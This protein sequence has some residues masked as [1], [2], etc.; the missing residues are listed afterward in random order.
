MSRIFLIALIFAA[1]I[2]RALLAFIPPTPDQQAAALG[3][4]DKLPPALRILLTPDATFP[5]IPVP[6]EN[7]W[8]A[9]HQ[10]PGQTFAKY[11]DT[12]PNRPDQYR[13][14]IYL[15]PLGEFPEN[16]SP[17]LETLRSYAA[18]YFQLEVQLLPAQLVDSNIFA[19]RANRYTG[20][21]QLLTA[22][23]F[24]Y[25]RDQLPSDAYCLLGLTMEDLYPA[26]A[27]NYVFGQASLSDRIGVYSF[28]R[29]DPA[30]FGEPRPTHIRELILRRSCKVL[31][32]E[33]GHMFG[34]HHCIYYHCVLNGSNHLAETDARPQHLCPICLRKIQHNTSLDAG[35]RYQDLANFYRQNQ[36]QPEQSWVETQLARSTTPSAP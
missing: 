12:S 28:A 1:A 17:S 35:K 31:V 13:R 6:E 24:D 5:S 32:H 25:L 30:F 3:P 36:W 15:L 20:K 7:D 8:L 2:S 29:Y 18:A 22:R 34:L 16:T 10:E 14:V 9:E 26:P 11:L 27:W 4:L 33:T 23:I 19:P 21:R